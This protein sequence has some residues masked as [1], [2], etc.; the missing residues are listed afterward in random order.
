MEVS[1]VFGKYIWM[2][3]KNNDVDMNIIFRWIYFGNEIVKKNYIVLI[4][5]FYLC[6]YKWKKY[7]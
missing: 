6:N 3:N 5:F 1:Y 2:I 4:C 7:F